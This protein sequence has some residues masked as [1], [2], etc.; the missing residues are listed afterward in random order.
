VQ[1]SKEQTEPFYDLSVEVKGCSNLLTSLKKY[2]QPE[3]MTGS[4]KW[5]AGHHGLQEAN[6][7]VRFVQFPPVLQVHFAHL[8]AQRSALQFVCTVFQNFAVHGVL[9]APQPQCLLHCIVCL[10]TATTVAYC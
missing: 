4:N 6:R 2:V 10:R 7:G 5:K 3:L 1:Y 8:F 9:K